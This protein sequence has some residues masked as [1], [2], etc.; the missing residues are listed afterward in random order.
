MKTATGRW[1][2]LGA[3]ALCAA[4]ALGAALLGAAP[5]SATSDKLGVE[6]PKEVTLSIAP[7]SY[8]EISFG[9]YHTYGDYRV[10]NGTLALDLSELAGAAEVSLPE[11]CYLPEPATIAV[12]DIWEV[13]ALGGTYDGPQFTIGLRTL[14]GAPAGAALS[15][16]YR[17]QAETNGPEDVLRTG[18][19][20]TSVKVESVPPPPSPDLSLSEPTPTGPVTPGTSLTVPVT[21]TNKGD[22][23]AE[24]FRLRVWNSYGLEAAADYAGCAWTP[25][26]LGVEDLLPGGLLDCTFDTVVEPGTTVTL[27]EPL[28]FTVAS[29]ALFERLDVGVEPLGSTQ[30]RHPEDNVS[31]ALIT[32]ENTADFTVRGDEVTGAAGEK[33]TATIEFRNQGPAWSANIGTGDPVGTITVTAPAGTTVVSAPES[34]QAESS[35]TYRC[36]LRHWVNPQERI[37][38]PFEL[39]VDRVIPNATGTVVLRPSPQQAPYAPQ[40]H[41]NRA[42]LVI[43]ATG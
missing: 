35:S 36:E 28:R 4:A 14:E 37:R 5:A 25:P 27:P 1:R 17:G 21:F 41:N 12:C 29:H 32:A 23:A 2:R 11:S 7:G 33:V 26:V 13:G 43:N 16:G 15:I 30:D 10:V 20:S 22:A 42:E 3:H 8:Q 31:S 40:P 9:L 24:G 6:A 34:C 19:G 39:R 38:F 18:W